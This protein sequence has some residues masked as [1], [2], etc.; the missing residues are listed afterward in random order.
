LPERLTLRY[1]ELRLIGLW[2]LAGG[3]L[4]VRLSGRRSGSVLCRAVGYRGIFRC[5]DS[6][7]AR[8]G[9]EDG[10]QSRSF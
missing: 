2:W 5:V 8:H 6:D 3:G 1:G 9:S 10:E 7:E 4:R